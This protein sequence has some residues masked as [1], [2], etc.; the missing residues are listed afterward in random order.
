MPRVRFPQYRQRWMIAIGPRA[1]VVAFP[2]G[3]AAV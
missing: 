2:F 3:I 1:F